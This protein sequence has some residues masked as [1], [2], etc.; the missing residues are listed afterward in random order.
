M[1]CYF[2]LFD[3]VKSPPSTQEFRTQLGCA[4]QR[5]CTVRD[6]ACYIV[7][8]TLKVPNFLT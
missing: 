3:Q 4:G 7:F 2:G 6:V 5:D 1:I 8:V